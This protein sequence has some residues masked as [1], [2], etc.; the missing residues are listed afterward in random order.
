MRFSSIIYGRQEAQRWD[1]TESR[2]QPSRRTTPGG[3]PGQPRRQMSALAPVPIELHPVGCKNLLIFF[4]RLDQL[5]YKCGVES[6]VVVYA[7]EGIPCGRNVAPL[8]SWRRSR[9]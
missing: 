1:T 8:Q 7:K 4:E 6:H 3:A 2:H 5:C 9:I